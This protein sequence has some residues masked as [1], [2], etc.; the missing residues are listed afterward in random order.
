MCLDNS[1]RCVWVT[2]EKEC[3][4]SHLFVCSFEDKNRC[5]AV[6]HFVLECDE[7]GNDY[8]QNIFNLRFASC[9]SSAGNRNFTLVTMKNYTESRLTAVNLRGEFFKAFFFQ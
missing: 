8:K 2:H 6:T 3:V 4:Y 7:A 1:P 9:A 5:V